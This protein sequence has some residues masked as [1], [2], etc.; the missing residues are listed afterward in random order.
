MQHASI[1]Q[2]GMDGGSQSVEA[3]S[4]F[5]IYNEWSKYPSCLLSS[6]SFMITKKDQFDSLRNAID[7]LLSE[8]GPATSMLKS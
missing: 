7:D 8:I 1:N 2:A 5:C 3:M 4:R 6:I